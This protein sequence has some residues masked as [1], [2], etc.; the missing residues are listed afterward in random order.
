MFHVEHLDS[1]Y[2]EVTMSYLGLNH[3]KFLNEE[4]KRNNITLDQDQKEKLLNYMDAILD[5][6]QHINL[7]RITD[8]EEF[9]LKHLID[10][11]LIL[12][13]I[14]ENLRSNIIDIGTGGGFPGVPLAIALPDCQFVLLDSTGKKLKVIEEIAKKLN[15]NNIKC[16]HARAEQASRLAEYRDKFDCAVSRA[17][18]LLPV[19]LELSLPF[20]KP[21][22]IFIALKN[23]NY[24]NELELSK[25]ILKNLNGEV[26]QI[27]EVELTPGLE[28]HIILEIIKK[29]KTPKKYPR[30]YKV[31]KNLYKS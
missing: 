16:L 2:L 28:N 7:T 27:K 30:D 14:P 29:S 10:S 20:V 21:D 5:Y 4:L 13:F 25:D 23:E 1:N 17:V 18:A 8:P 22:G 19:L 31:I 12:E 3:L 9:I 24:K 11:L 15:I 6:N 26:S